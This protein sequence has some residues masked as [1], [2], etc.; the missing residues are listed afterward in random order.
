MRLWY[1]LLE[2]A[3][4]DN[5]SP[6]SKARLVGRARRL[7]YLRKGHLP[8]AI[9]VRNNSISPFTLPRTVQSFIVRGTPPSH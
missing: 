3:L 9:N 5:Y 2:A 8:Q 1:S 4:N 7:C 6:A